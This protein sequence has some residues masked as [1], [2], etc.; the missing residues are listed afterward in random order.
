MKTVRRYFT[1]IELLVVIAVIAILAALL[2]PALSHAKELAYI[3]LCMNNQRQLSQMVSFYTVDSD[4][5]LPETSGNIGPANYTAY[6]RRLYEAGMPLPKSSWHPSTN[7]TPVL[8]QSVLYCPSAV[9]F[10]GSKEII[11]NCGAGGYAYSALGG[12]R[13]ATLGWVNPRQLNTGVW[14]GPFRISEIKRPSMKFQFADS[15]IVY[16][17]YAGQYYDKY[18]FDNCGFRTNGYMGGFSVATSSKS[19]PSYPFHISNTNVIHFDS[20]ATTYKS[21][22]FGPEKVEERTYPYP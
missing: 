15:E 17:G 20:S 9:R 19:P 7:I 11:S 16:I 3:K 21:P 10:C 12:Q 6:P 5:W 14:R 2:F 4:D 13:D 8:K 18:L 1:L 22:V